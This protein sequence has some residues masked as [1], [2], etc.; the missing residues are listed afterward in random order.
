MGG[1][2]DGSK[3]KEV[4]P[5]PVPPP[6]PIPEVQEEAEEFALKEKKGRSGFEQTFLTGSLKPK[7]TGKKR[8]LG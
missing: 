5:P 1:L 4:K 8:K 2:L 6:L 7:P 3:P